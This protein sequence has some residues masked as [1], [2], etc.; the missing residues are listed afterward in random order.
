[1]NP[2]FAVVGH[3]NKGKS[4]IV[5]T[6]AQDDSVAISAQSGTTQRAEPIQVRVG[7]SHYTLI[8]TPG[9]QRP[10]RVL[11]WL[12]QHASSADER[13][14]AVQKF[15][16]DP[17]CQSQFP[18]EVELLHPIVNG[19]AILYVVDGSRPYGAEYEAEMEI[20]RWTGQASMALINPIENE[21]YITSWKQALAQYF[22]I[23][24][25][26]NAMQA[27]FD[28]QLSILEAFS[29]LRDDWHGSIT[30]L[31]AEYERLRAWQRQQSAATLSELLTD[32]CT[33][34]VSQRVLEKQQA[35]QLK[36]ILEKRYFAYLKDREQEAHATLKKIFRYHNLTL[37]GVDLPTEEDLFDT[38]KWVLWGLNRQQLLVAA[39]MAGAATGAVVDLG[40]AGH[41]LFMGALAGGVLAGGSAWFGAD[42]LADFKLKG[43]P[44][45]GYEA[46]QGPMKNRNFPYVLLSRFLFLYY[47]LQKR[48]H[49]QRDSLEI[50]EGDLSSRISKLDKEHQ[51]S[52][53]RVM[54]RLSRQRS[55]ESPAKALEPLFQ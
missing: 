45:G 12:Q 31:I 13:L 23:V 5:A 36:P 54:D 33:Y 15:I 41:S 32:L 50:Q 18:D 1:M 7:D 55:L 52:I 19:A 34:Q 49:A 10:T 6:L 14:D 9:F 2:R 21:Q 25:V 16:Q 27:D 48:T 51:K 47:A 35:E 37:Q 53:H 8:D 3:P 26:F 24:R 39:T 46:R 30:Q 29:H 28:K 4:S 38:E 40:L 17:Q 11:D 43:L 20:L 42:R 22:K 44:V